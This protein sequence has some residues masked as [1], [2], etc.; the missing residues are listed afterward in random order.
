MACKELLDDAK[1]GCADLVFKD[2]CLEILAKAKQ[3]LT[4]EQ[5]EELSFYAAEIMK[6]KIIRNPRK[7]VEIQ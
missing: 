7:K 3:V 1:L 4:H 6:E 5:F 2:V